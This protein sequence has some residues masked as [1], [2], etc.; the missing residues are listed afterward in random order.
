MRRPNYVD[1]LVG[2]LRDPAF[3]GDLHLYEAFTQM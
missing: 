2:A 3:D 1:D